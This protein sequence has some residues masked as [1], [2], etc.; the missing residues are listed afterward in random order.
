MTIKMGNCLK[1]KE[2]G[3]EHAKVL[4]SQPGHVKKRSWVGMIVEL[5]PWRFAGRGNHGTRHKTGSDSCGYCSVDGST[6]SPATAIKG[7]D[8]HCQ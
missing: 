7:L 1:I 3:E 2:V 8:N 5:L 6:E 4:S